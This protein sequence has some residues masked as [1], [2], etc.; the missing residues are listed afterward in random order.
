MVTKLRTPKDK[1]ADHRCSLLSKK[2]Q[3]SPRKMSLHPRRDISATFTG[4]PSKSTTQ[5]VSKRFQSLKHEDESVF[6]GSSSSSKSSKSRKLDMLSPVERFIKSKED[7]LKAKKEE[8]MQ[9][10]SE[11]N[12]MFDQIKKI[13]SAVGR[14]GQRCSTC[15]QKFHTV[16]FMCW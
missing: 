13:A 5:S 12:G 7:E 3:E 8:V 9:K 6:T 11:L 15:H 14:T 4:C 1:S 16:R 2:V 10:K